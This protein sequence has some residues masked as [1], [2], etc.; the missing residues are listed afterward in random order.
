M[1][2][3]GVR[4]GAL[5]LAA[6]ALAVS[7]RAGAATVY[8]LNS[9]WSNASNPNGPWA[10]LQGA[11]P[12]PADADWTPLSDTDPAYTKKSGQHIAQPAW[13][14]GNQAGSFLPAWFK[15]TVTPKTAGADWKRGDIVFHTTDNFNGQGS[16]PASVLFTVPAAGK[17]TISGY[18]YNGRN[19]LNRDQVWQV[20]VAGAVVASGDLPG[21]GSV[22]RKN[23]TKFKLPAMKV[24]VDE[25]IQLIATEN[26]G[27]DGAG[28]FVG[29]DLTIKLSP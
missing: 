25:T 3:Y 21:N 1:A 7:A 6:A 14:P 27:N 29:T 24:E 5:I 11:T 26:G 22:T 16:G 8:D 4:A 18:V 28:D 9:Q 12:L 19:N 23:P 10:L 13:A 17:A 2:K 20:L 15:A